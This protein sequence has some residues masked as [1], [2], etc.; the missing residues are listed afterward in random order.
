L[1]DMAGET[2]I[3]PNPSK[4]SISVRFKDGLGAQNVEL[5]VYTMN[6]R[7][8]RRQTFAA[9]G[10]NIYHIDVSGMANGIYAVVAKLIKNGELEYR[11]VMAAEIIR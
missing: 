8:V 3:Y 10:Q 11:K 9:N 1:P 5:S 2:V 7:L 6:L 4:D